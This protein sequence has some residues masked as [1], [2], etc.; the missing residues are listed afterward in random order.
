MPDKDGRM[1]IGVQDYRPDSIADLKK[2]AKLLYAVQKGEAKLL[3]AVYRN[4]HEDIWIKY[5][6]DWTEIY[7]PEAKVRF[8]RREDKIIYE[9]IID[10]D[11]LTDGKVNQ[12]WREWLMKELGEE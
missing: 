2:L 5:E 3:E 4:E 6:W 7:N 10:G 12:L 1:S 9:V 8:Y 11:M